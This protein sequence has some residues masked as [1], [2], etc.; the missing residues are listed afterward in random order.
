MFEGTLRLTVL[1]C[2]AWGA[3]LKAASILAAE[4]IILYVHFHFIFGGPSETGTSIAHA[5]PGPRAPQ[6][7]NSFSNTAFLGN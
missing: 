1:V 3:Q 5:R 7:K 2:L 4:A 6:T